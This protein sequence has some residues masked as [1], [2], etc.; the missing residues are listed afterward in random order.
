MKP[1]IKIFSLGGT[2]A[3]VANEHTDG[4]APSLGADALISG[5]PELSDLADIETETFRKLPSPYITFDDIL[6]L[7]REIEKSK[8]SGLNGIVV[9]QGT[10]TLEETAFLLD[11]IYTGKVPV[12][13][14]GAMRNPTLPGAD[15]PA[16]LLHSVMVASAKNA[17][18]LGVIV[19]FNGDIHA[20]RYVRKNHTQ[21]PAAFCSAP[22]GKIGWIAENSVR[23]ISQPLS[24]QIFE[25]ENRAVM[26]K[27]ALLKVSMS[28][29]GCLINSVIEQKFDG[30]VI[31]ATG[32]G[33]VTEKMIE[34]LMRAIAL[35]PV[36]MVSRTGCGEVLR[37]TYMFPGSEMDLLDRGIINGG[38]LDGPKARIMLS[39][40]IARKAKKEDIKQAFS[41]WL[42]D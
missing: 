15:G 21:N 4:V 20:A 13:I 34:P 32:G 22:I 6:A 8:S 5:I 30:L 25:L 11:R 29:D 40:L 18:D 42:G 19:V 26:G 28:D 39:L 9:T 10:D 2:I 35:M 1:K 17:S 23:I 7:A 27:V 14:T 38:W 12:V 31:E 24:R 16:N 41:S 36:V 37:E 3:S 33:H